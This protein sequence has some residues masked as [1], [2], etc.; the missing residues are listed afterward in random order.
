[1]SA[2]SDSLKNIIGVALAVCF[3]CSILVS[4]AAVVLKP[5]QVAN[6]RLEKIRNIL[7]AGD[8]LE[9][10]KN[11]ET[12]LSLWEKS[13]NDLDREA[14]AEKI[15]VFLFPD[16]R[17][18]KSTLFHPGGQIISRNTIIL[19]DG[20]D[21]DPKKILRSYCSKKKINSLQALNNLDGYI[22]Y[23]EIH[24]LHLTLGIF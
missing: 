17:S 4:T 1:M 7:I 18:S 16:S 20:M 8:L 2:T 12:I 15:T 21:Y 6:Q 13:F 5:R 3:V 24:L 14:N 22:S 11:I 9:E 10:E 19:T 23:I